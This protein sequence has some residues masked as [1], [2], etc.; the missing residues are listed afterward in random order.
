METVNAINDILTKLAMLAPVLMAVGAGW[1]YLPVIKKTINEGIIPILNALLTFFI[2]FGG[3][4]TVAQAGILGDAGKFLSVP[5]SAFLSILFS[6]TLSAI[7]DKFIK[8]LT[9]PSPYTI[10]QNTQPK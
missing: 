1:K 3:G 10:L 8:P 5:A 7:H 9:P 4:T 2:A 6:Y